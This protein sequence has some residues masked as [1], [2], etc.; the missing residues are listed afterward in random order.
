M[1]KFLKI[2]INTWSVTVHVF[3]S[4]F[5]G[6]RVMVQ[7]T[8]PH[9]D[10]MFCIPMHVIRNQSSQATTATEKGVVGKTRMVCDSGHILHIVPLLK[11]AL[12]GLLS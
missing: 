10:Y 6:T 5:H 8:Q 4:N 7:Y 12:I 1:L 11:V 9:T 3:V 2:R